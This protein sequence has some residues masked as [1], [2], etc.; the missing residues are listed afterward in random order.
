MVF[1]FNP[2]GKACSPGDDIETVFECEAAATAIPQLKQ[3]MQRDGQVYKRDEGGVT[4][5]HNPHGCYVYN[6]VSLNFN[7]DNTKKTKI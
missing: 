5:S 4:N 2:E 6:M 1:K 3:G 7:K